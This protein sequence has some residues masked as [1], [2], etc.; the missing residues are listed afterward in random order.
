MTYWNI[1]QYIFLKF[2]KRRKKKER[3]TRKEREKIKKSIGVFFY[4]TGLL[5]V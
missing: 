2:E 5:A 3:M 4:A 1:I